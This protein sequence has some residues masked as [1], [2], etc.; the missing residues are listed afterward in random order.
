MNYALVNVTGELIATRS[1]DIEGLD[2]GDLSVVEVSDE[3]FAAFVR[4]EARWS[5]DDQAFT[6]DLSILNAKLLAKIDRE[7]GE[8][9]KQFITDIAGQ[10]LTYQRKETEARAYVLDDA[11]T[12]PFLQA[13]ATATG[14]T[15]S[16]LAAAVIT[17]ADE[18]IEM[19]AAIEGLRMG[20]K[21]AVAAA[22]TKATKEAAANVDWSSLLG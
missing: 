8:F 2:F 16:D 18:W 14:V 6:P 22:S 4:Q 13:E 10:E 11:G 17:Q 15:M 7:A 3:D 9:R 20:A 5:I 19:G 1:G 12:Y 21:V